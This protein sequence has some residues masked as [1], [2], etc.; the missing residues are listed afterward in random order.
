MLLF[1]LVILKLYANIISYFNII[2]K[3]LYSYNSR[4]IYYLN[5][6]IGKGSFSLTI[7]HLPLYANVI[8]F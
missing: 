4:I 7:I 3:I 5:F 1:F 6:E 8:V 2:I